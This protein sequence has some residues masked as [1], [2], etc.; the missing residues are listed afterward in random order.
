MWYIVKTDYYKED[1][2]VTEFGK[3]SII[4]NTY[5]PVYRKPLNVQGGVNL[6]SLNFAQPSAEYCSSM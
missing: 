6:G 3:I 4:Q 5:L 2:A 1:E